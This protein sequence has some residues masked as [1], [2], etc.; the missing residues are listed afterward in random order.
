MNWWQM[1]S[2]LISPLETTKRMKL[3]S[4]E[5]TEKSNNPKLHAFLSENFE[6]LFISLVKF[7]K[8]IIL[9]HYNSDHQPTI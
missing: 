4:L 9:I 1:S 7:R 6:L 3:Y 2:K 5:Y 8:K